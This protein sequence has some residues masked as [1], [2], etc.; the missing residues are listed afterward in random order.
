M[1]PG[2]RF[3][4]FGMGRS[5]SSLLVSLLNFHPQIKCEGELFRLRRWPKIL[6][7]VARI[8]QRLPLPYLVYRQA[9]SLLLTR[10]TV[11]GFKLLGRAQIADTPGF[12]RFAAQ[13]GWKIIH[14][15][16]KSLFD[17][18]ISG[19]VGN[20][21]KRFFGHNQGS[22]PVINVT[23][24]VDSFK[25]AMLRAINISRDDRQ[26]LADIPHLALTYEDDLVYDTYWA[27]TMTRICQ[28]LDVATPA[29]VKAVFPNPGAALQ[30]NCYQL[31]RTG[32]TGS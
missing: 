8:W 3:V 32:G 6:Q 27:A 19:Q 9:R 31:R 4:I 26:L 30:R 5:G 10:K 29:S 7:P 20:Q 15:E 18:V 22:E 21:T 12:I 17:Q 1:K 13:S 14:L 24:P 25:T 11:Y 16:R 23:I 2:T 28:F